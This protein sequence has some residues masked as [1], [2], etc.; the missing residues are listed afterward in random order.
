LTG[1]NETSTILGCYGIGKEGE[2]VEAQQTSSL[3]QHYDVDVKYIT[4]LTF[5]DEKTKIMR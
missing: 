1:N 4:S 2:G 3:G 5:L